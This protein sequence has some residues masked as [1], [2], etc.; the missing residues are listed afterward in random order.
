MKYS[1]YTP[2]P[3]PP[4]VLLNALQSLPS[5]PFCSSL[6]FEWVQASFPCL[7]QEAHHPYLHFVLSAPS[8]LSTLHTLTTWRP[9]SPHH[10]SA[11]LQ[12]AHHPSPRGPQTSCSTPS[13]TL[14][15]S[16][17]PSPITTWPAQ[18]YAYHH[19]TSQRPRVPPPWSSADYLVKYLSSHFFFFFIV[20][21]ILHFCVSPMFPFF[22]VYFLNVS[23]I[24]SRCLTTSHLTRP[25]LRLLSYL[26]MSLFLPFLVLTLNQFMPL[27]D[28]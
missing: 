2:L 14:L 24:P 16:R 10:V 11:A 25:H 3:R 18:K 15:P 28:E 27:S 7:F 9:K 21:V 23:T 6:C 12:D 13:F 1:V 22:C 8:L 20:P 5:S 17:R 4:C 19:V 26:I